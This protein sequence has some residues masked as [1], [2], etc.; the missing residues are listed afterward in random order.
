MNN[1][2]FIL[3]GGI[4]QVLHRCRGKTP[5]C[6]DAKFKSGDVVRVRNLKHLKGFPREA[7]VAVA[8]P[9]G[10]SP[11][12]ALADL[13]GVPRPMMTSVG[14]RVINYILIND[15][16]TKPYLVKERD[17]MPSGK[18]PIEIGEVRLAPDTANGSKE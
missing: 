4:V 9:P 7:V 12:D 15:G 16:D 6:P 3:G 18:P 2:I 1:G 13:V 14:S 8:V 5:A 10:F 17:L 11:D